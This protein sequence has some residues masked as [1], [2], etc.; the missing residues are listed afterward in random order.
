MSWLG[1]RARVHVMAVRPAGADPL[2][3][4]TDRPFTT[5]HLQEEEYVSDAK[6]KTKAAV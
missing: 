1:G 6:E 5:H 4:P 3:L 2:C